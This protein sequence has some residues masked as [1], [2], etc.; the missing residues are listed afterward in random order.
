MT[1]V[2]LSVVVT[3][4]VTV[5]EAFAASEPRLQT[6]VGFPLQLPWLAEAETS[7]TFPGS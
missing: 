4:I 3:V 7:V 5:A 1:S 2:P 6:I